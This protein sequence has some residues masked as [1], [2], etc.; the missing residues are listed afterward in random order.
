MHPLAPWLILWASLLLRCVFSLS[1][2]CLSEVLMIIEIENF[3][4]KAFHQPTLHFCQIAV[5]FQWN[6]DPLT[7]LNPL[8]VELFSKDGSLES[9]KQY[10][11]GISAWRQTT[12]RMEQAPGIC[13][14]STRVHF[15]NVCT[16]RREPENFGARSVLWLR[17]VSWWSYERT[18]IRS[19]Y[20]VPK[21]GRGL[22]VPKA[23]P[24]PV[25]SKDKLDINNVIFPFA[26]QRKDLPSTSIRTAL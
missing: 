4:S 22:S 16:G 20:V 13:F 18:K 9:L 11:T 14:W 15:D 2:V 10:M 5:T 24:S 7:L 21:G 6:H 1:V 17:S 8:I 25:T 12:W 23:W 26:T 19:L 3:S